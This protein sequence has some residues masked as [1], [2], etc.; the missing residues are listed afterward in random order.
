MIT[1]VVQVLPLE[2]SQ[3]ETATPSVEAPSS[4][5]IRFPQLETDLA[6]VLT[7]LVAVRESVDLELLNAQPSL[8]WP[9]ILILPAAIDSPG[10]Q[11]IGIR[12]YEC[13]HNRITY[14]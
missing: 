14:S 13:F 1:L 12:V 9:T 3:Q 2:P 10:V 7:K 11:I 5:R 6:N 8:H 4:A